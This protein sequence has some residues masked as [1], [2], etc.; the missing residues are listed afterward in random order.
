MIR[1]NEKKVILGIK[2]IMERLQIGRNMA[3]R[4][5]ASD[6]LHV[7]RINE[8]RFVHEDVFEKWLKGDQ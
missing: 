3:A 6:E 2:D 4:I 8:K 5:L 7:F 1:K